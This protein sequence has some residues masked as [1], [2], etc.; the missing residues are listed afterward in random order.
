MNRATLIIQCSDQKGIVAA[1]SEFLFAN[2]GNILEID[3]HVDQELGMF[4]MRASWELDTFALKKELIYDTFEKEIATK[5]A[6]DFQLYFN[7]RKPKMALFV[8]KLSHCLFD[9][10]SRYH[11]GQFDV[12]IP[13][14]ISNHNDLQAIVQAFDIPFVHLP[15]DKS[16]KKDVEEKQLQ[17]LKRHEVDFVV[18]ARYMQILSEDFIKAYPNK[19][20]NIHHSF[21]PAFVGA[22]PYH[23]AYA[24]GVK[25]IG[26]TAHYVTEELDAGPI[27]EQDVARVRHHNTISDLVQMGQDIEKVVLSKAIKYHLEHKVLAFGNK[28]VIFY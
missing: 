14:V 4:F 1:V 20:I 24:R 6:M 11:A 2:K 23:A 7:D 15:V 25:I 5:F 22:K 13:L 16:N 21:L 27:I 8:S 26:A 9:I 19:I 12:E 10:L 17:L 18:L 3:Q 28:T